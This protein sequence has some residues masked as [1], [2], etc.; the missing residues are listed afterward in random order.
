MVKLVGSADE[1]W[2]DV[3]PYVVHF[4]KAEGKRKAYDNSLSILSHRRIEARSRFGT[5]RQYA[6]AP[7]S[8]CFSEIPLHNLARLADKRGCYG[9]GFRKEFIVERDGGP[10][11]YAYKDTPRANALRTM[12]SKAKADQDDS[13]WKIAPFVD[14]PGQYGPKSYF[15]EWEREWRHVGNLD[16]KETDAAFLIIPEN[17]HSQARGFFNDAEAENLGPNYRC[18]FIDPYWNAAK[19]KAA[20]MKLRRDGTI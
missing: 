9:I 11:M 15:Y 7:L 8:I 18:A 12:A 4:T 3:S 20:F 16:F 19:V 5:G 2:P 10:I 13:I 14:Q 6:A 17:L 1:N